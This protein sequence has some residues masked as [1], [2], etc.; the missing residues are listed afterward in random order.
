V[1]KELLAIPIT[2]F[3]LPSSFGI[4]IVDPGVGV[5]LLPVMVT[6]PLTGVE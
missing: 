5:P 6:S 4:V 3:P 1:L 2:L